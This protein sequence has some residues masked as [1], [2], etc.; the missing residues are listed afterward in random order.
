MRIVLQRVTEA[1]VTMGKTDTRRIGKGLVAL[2]GFGEGDTQKEADFLAAKMCELRIFEDGGGNMN[3]SLLDVGGGALLVPNFTLYASCKKGRRPSFTN[4]MP[5]E[6]ASL[7]FG[8]FVGVVKEIIPDVQTGVFGSHM[9]VE[10]D[11]Y[12]P[13]TIIL[14]S[15][16]IM[17]KLHM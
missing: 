16:E 8:Y 10:I 3:L 9:L 6:K 5:P 12:G 7:L 17:P 15:G 11:G 2:V 4:A 1:A 13:V 14:D